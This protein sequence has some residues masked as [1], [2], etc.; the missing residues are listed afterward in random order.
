ME[1][2]PVAIAVVEYGGRYLAGPRPAGLPLAGLWEFP[3]GK[4]EAGEFPQDAAVRECAEETGVV[5]RVRGEF[6]AHVCRYAHGPVH[7]HFFDCEPLSE[8]ATPREPF[9]WLDQDQMGRVEFPAGNRAVLEYL[10]Q[11]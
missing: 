5:I 11:R 1:P 6:P 3:G 4:I 2:T 7:L 10:L 9:R 8:P